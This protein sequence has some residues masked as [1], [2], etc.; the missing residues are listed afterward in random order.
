[1]SDQSVLQFIK[2]A[3]DGMQHYEEQPAGRRSLT[4]DEKKKIAIGAGG[5]A[6]GALVGGALGKRTMAR[7]LSDPHNLATHAMNLSGG[8]KVV[9]KKGNKLAP[10]LFKKVLKIKGLGK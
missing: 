1:M 9:I 4:R 8:K 2:S 5:V 6:A 10:R 7:H 3:Q